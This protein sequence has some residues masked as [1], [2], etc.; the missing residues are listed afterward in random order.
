MVTTSLRKTQSRPSSRPAR[1]QRDRRSSTLT[2]R[3]SSPAQHPVPAL[4]STT[5]TQSSGLARA[6]QHRRRV[7]PR[8]LASAH[9]P[10][11]RPLSHR[12]DTSRRTRSRP[13]PRPFRSRTRA[14]SQHSSGTS[15]CPARR[16][17]RRSRARGAA[18]PRRPA[19]RRCSSSR[20]RWVRQRGR[21]EHR[22]RSRRRCNRYS[23]R[24]ARQPRYNNNN[25]SSSRAA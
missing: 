24:A 3:R 10:T 5:S 9:R 14:Q 13:Q 16:A 6:P 1:A 7:Q 21:W 18:C 20:C 8:L 2:T 12:P 19:W 15:C 25:S 11:P 4:H 22:V 17:A 23:R